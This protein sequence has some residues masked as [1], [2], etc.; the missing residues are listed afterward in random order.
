MRAYHHRRRHRSDCRYTGARVASGCRRVK[1]RA[2]MLPRPPNVDRASLLLTTAL[3]STLLIATLLSPSPASAVATCPPA[4]FPP[5]GPI[6]IVNP[7]DDI[8]CTNVFDRSADGGAV[9]GL[10][11]SGVNEDISLNNSGELVNTDDFATLGIF[12][13]TY[14]A[15]SSIDIVNRG[16]ITVDSGIIAVGIRAQTDGANSPISIV[17]SGDIAATGD[18][19]RAYGIDAFTD[20]DDSAIEIRNGGD[21][22]VTTYADFNAYGIKAD[23]N[24]V[25]SSLI[26]VNRGDIAVTTSGDDIYAFGIEADTDGADSSVSIVNTGNIAVTAPGDDATATGIHGDTDG[27]DNPVSIVNR[28]VVTVSGYNADGIEGVTRDDYSSVTIDNSGNVTVVAPYSGSGIFARTFTDNSPIEI[29][30]SGDI[31]V[32]APDVVGEGISAV[33]SGDN[34]PIVVRNR[35]NIQVTAEGF[36][37]GIDATSPFGGENPI[38]IVNRGDLAILSTEGTAEGILA[39]TDGTSPIDIYNSGDIDAFG[40]I[41]VHG[42]DAQTEGADSAISIDN[43][44]DIALATAGGNNFSNAYGVE[45]RTEEAGSSIAI[46]NSGDMALA[47]VGPYADAY[48][49]FARAEGDSSS[50]E[51]LNRGDLRLRADNSGYGI[52]AITYANTS[53]IAIVNRGDVEVEARTDSGAAIRA[54]TYSRSSQIE[55]LNEANLRVRSEAANAYGVNT[56]TGGLNSPIA[57]LN[58]G[59]ITA[60][61]AVSSYGIFAVTEGNF[62]PIDI[63]NTAKIT[64]DTTG[65]YA[66]AGGAGSPIAIYNSGV[67]DP[68]VGISVSTLDSDSPIVIENVGSVVGDLIGIK[69]SSPA[70]TTIIN[71]GDISAGSLLAVASYE[72]G[73]TKIYNSGLIKGYIVLDADDTFINQ[74]GG[75][76]EAKLTSDFGPG[77]DLLSNEAGARVQAATDRNAKETSSLVHLERFQNQGVIS[78]QDGGTGDVFIISNTPGKSDLHFIASGRSQLQMDASLRG[79]QLQT[80]TFVIDGDVTGRTRLTVN[81]TN[82]GPGAFNPQGILVVN[83]PNGNVASNAFYLPQPIDTGLFDYDLFFVPTGSGF[84]ELRSFPGGGAHVLPQLLT[85]SQDIWYATSETWLDRT[86]DLRVLL[87]GGGVPANL[88]DGAPMPAAPSTPGVWIRG[89][90]TWLDQDDRPRPRLTAAP[91]ATISTAISISARSRAGSISASGAC[92]RKATRSCSAFSAAAVFGELTYDRLA[93]TFDIEGGEVGGYATYLSGGLFVDNLLKVNFTEFDPSANAGPPRQPRFHHLG[94]PHRCR[95]PLRRAA[96]GRCS[97]SRKRRSPWPGPTSTI[98]PSPATR[99]ISATRPIRAGAWACASARAS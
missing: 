78:L 30:N 49:I 17:N 38:S 47:T 88:K 96:P 60:S 76:F 69:A 31:E 53:P 51:I 67:I 15:N 1:K 87:S 21:L 22:L 5:P 83:V 74:N 52:D 43:R 73:D 61:A 58:E 98:S 75:I 86:A 33:T 14:G 10:L 68:E 6:A 81:N 85:A 55:I 40:V 92:G 28:G 93:R 65:I 7:A 95:L 94:L 50:I 29:R 26:V 42:I 62:S 89:S 80:D 8:A 48:G 2:Q 63:A 56:Y 64:A 44:G 11:T 13:I 46:A 32:S 97:S 36:S 18:T 72:P 25:D 34:S 77:D 99:S 12:A 3:T 39:D 71:S 59:D 79:G 54:F 70:D 27:I 16:D 35:G 90:G 57:I 4:L 37:R 82:P 91:T 20:G 84:F 24:G 23:T 66:S 41:N 45:A 9:I 19:Y